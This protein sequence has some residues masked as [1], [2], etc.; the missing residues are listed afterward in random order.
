MRRRR[1]K[2]VPAASPDLEIPR[3]SVE[4]TG[5][6]DLVAKRASVEETPVVALGRIKLVLPVEAGLKEGTNLNPPS[7]KSSGS[8]GEEGPMAAA[9]EKTLREIAE[10]EDEM[11]SQIKGAPLPTRSEA[12][13]DQGYQIWIRRSGITLR[14]GVPPATTLSP[15][16]RLSSG[17]SDQLQMAPTLQVRGQKYNRKATTRRDPPAVRAE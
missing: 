5:K 14:D 9:I 12:D 16:S 17:T 2:E 1:H 6:C 10:D 7:T 3:P 15:S 4:V 13:E 8:S 11:W